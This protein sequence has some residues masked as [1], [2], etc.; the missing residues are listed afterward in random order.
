ML[1]GVLPS[2]MLSLVKLILGIAS[3][4]VILMIVLMLTSS[5]QVPSAGYT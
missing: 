1:K 2:M 4:A 5:G 3:I